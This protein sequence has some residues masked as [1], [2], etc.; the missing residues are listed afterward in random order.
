M[1]CDEVVLF[2]VGGIF[3]ENNAFFMLGPMGFENPI[4]EK[5][6]PSEAR[7]VWYIAAT[8]PNKQP[9]TSCKMYST[10]RIEVKCKSI[11]NHLFG[12]Q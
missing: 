11:T 3:Y 9:M 2:Q 8:P 1:Y 5:R 10:L 7:F 12:S 4:L 6:P